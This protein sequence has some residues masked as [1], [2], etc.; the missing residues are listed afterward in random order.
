[1]N[2]VSKNSYY[3]FLLWVFKASNVCYKHPSDGY[4]RHEKQLSSS[5]VSIIS[6]LANN[7]C[8]NPN[9]PWEIRRRCHTKIKCRKHTRS[10]RDVEIRPYHKSLIS[11]AS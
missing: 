11:Y 6:N 10:T 1:M 2:V 3:L 8:S 9:N 4:P 7:R 5:N